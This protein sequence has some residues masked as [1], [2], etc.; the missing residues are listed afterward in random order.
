ML[1]LKNALED[2]ILDVQ[3]Y[4][5]ITWAK[6]CKWFIFCCPD[7][8]TLLRKCDEYDACG[9][10]WCPNCADCPCCPEGVDHCPGWNT[11]GS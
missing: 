3:W 7:C 6:F 5:W 10:V 2:L 8:G 4:L 9:I 1:L 11:E